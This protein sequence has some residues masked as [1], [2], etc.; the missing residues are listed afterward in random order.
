MSDTRVGY[1][2]GHPAAY[3]YRRENNNSAIADMAACNVAQCDFSLSSTCSSDIITLSRPPSSSSLK[4]N[5]HSF[6]HASPCLRNQLPKELR[7]P[8][9]HKDL[10]LSSDHTCQFVI[11]TAT[12]HY[13]FSLPL[14]AQNSS[15]PQIFSSIVHLPFHPPG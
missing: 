13:S 9:D 15:F 10:S 1:P 2:P 4:V 3:D 11:T 6:R 12:I 8:T 14:Q 7:L 5:N